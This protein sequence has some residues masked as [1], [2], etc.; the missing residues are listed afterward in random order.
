MKVDSTLVNELAEDMKEDFKAKRIVAA[1]LHTLAEDEEN[2]G[3]RDT[4]D[5]FLFVDTEY[6]IGCPEVECVGKHF[7]FFVSFGTVPLS[8]QGHLHLS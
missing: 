8:E 3:W 7:Q 1:D 5:G 6:G 2:F 4:V